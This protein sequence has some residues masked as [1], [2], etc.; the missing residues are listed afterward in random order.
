MALRDQ[1]VRVALDWQEAYG[2]APSITGALAEYD[3]AI[4]VGCTEAEYKNQMIGRSVVAA[5]YDFEHDNKRYQVKAGRPSGRS[6]SKITLVAKPKNYDWD[7]FV[8]VH[9][10]T[11]YDPLEIWCWAVEEF[12]KKFGDKKRLSPVDIRQGI[13]I[14]PRE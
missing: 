10:R 6:G 11:N 3:A 7:F 8:W 13:K 5:G 4:L 14:F 9:Y 12:Q 1:L 2:N